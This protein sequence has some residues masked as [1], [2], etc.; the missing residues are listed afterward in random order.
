MYFLKNSS[1]VYE[2]F[3]EYVNMVKNFTGLKVKMLRTDNGGKHV[4]TDF[5]KYCASKWIIHQYTNP[6][7]PE[8]KGVS[9]RLNRT[10]AESAKSMIFHANMPINFW[11]QAVNTTVQLHN[12]SPSKSLNMKTPY[13]CWFGKKPDVSNLKIFGSV[14]YMHTPS[15]LRQKLDPRSRKAVFIGYPP[16]TKG[17]KLYDVEPKKFV[18]SKDVV[19][20][21]NKFH[22]F[23]TVTK[24][25]I[26][27]EDPPEEKLGTNHVQN[28]DV[29]NQ[30]YLPEIANEENLPPVGASYEENIMKQEQNFGTKR[31][32][33]APKK[34]SPDECNFVD[35]LTAENEE[36]QTIS[37]ALNSNYDDAK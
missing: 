14:C 31:Q 11:A 34:F 15:N 30:V 37:E 19:S 23:E 10:L 9:E 20:Y 5:S 27:R 22:D 12:R 13:E 2:K 6:Y 4:S 18:R 3:E 7:T 21:E 24:E 25:L 1:E 17:Y 36:P 28:H 16:D 33:K 29:E 32:R 35:S 8:Q 26:I